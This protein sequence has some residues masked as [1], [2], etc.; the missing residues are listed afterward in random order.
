MN[1]T[2]IEQVVTT[3]GEMILQNIGTEHSLSFKLDGLYREYPQ[4]VS[5]VDRAAE[6]Y[7]IDCIRREYP[8]HEIV[9]EESGGNRGMEEWTWIVDPVDG[10]VNFSRGLP[11]FSVSVALAYRGQVQLGAVYVPSVREFYFATRNEEATCNNRPVKVS[12]TETLG[13]A[14][15]GSSV[16]RS[17]QIRKCEQVLTSIL[18]QVP[19]VR[20]F[21]SSALEICWIARGRMDARIFA[22]SEIWDHAAA[23]L[24][25]EQ[26][27]GVV[28]DWNGS[29][30][31]TTTNQLLVS[32]GLLHR[33]LLSVLSVDSQ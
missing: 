11:L 6:T 15:I 20:M 9:A 25:V 18:R 17:Y 32:N 23:A 7:I 28:T 24:I 29:N 26:A 30:W 1:R 13:A 14:I 21:A 2:F 27:G 22:H 33:D 31:D 19:N 4:A 3:A 16:Q 5:A 8:N 12:C 10:T